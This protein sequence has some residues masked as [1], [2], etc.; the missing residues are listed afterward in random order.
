[1]RYELKTLIERGEVAQRFEDEPPCSLC[2]VL[3]YGDLHLVPDK[4]SCWCEICLTSYD[5]DF[6]YGTFGHDID[7]KWALF[8]FFLYFFFHFFH[9]CPLTKY[10]TD[11][12]DALSWL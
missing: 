8:L 7:A 9:F 12:P 11:V 10:D 1:M 3:Y 6:S 5:A 4:V 2:S